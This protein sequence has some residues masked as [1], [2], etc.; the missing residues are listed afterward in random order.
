MSKNDKKCQKKKK[1]TMM[2][3]TLKIQKEACKQEKI[4]QKH[5]NVRKQPPSQRKR[6]KVNAQTSLRRVQ[7]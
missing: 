1:R 6:Q 4:N 3:N 2:K 5:K 7:I